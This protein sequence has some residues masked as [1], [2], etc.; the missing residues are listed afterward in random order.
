MPP[1]RA[2]AHAS[3][4]GASSS[5]T[6]G[7]RAL[8]T[9]Q[10]RE[11]ESQQRMIDE[12]WEQ[13]VHTFKIVQP[14]EWPR[15]QP[16]RL[17]ETPEQR[18]RRHENLQGEVPHASTSTSTSHKNGDST[19][20]Y[21][22]DTADDDI[23]VPPNGYPSIS[24]KHS[25]VSI[26]GG[27]DSGLS[28]DTYP[29]DEEELSAEAEKGLITETMEI[30]P[31]FRA[32]PKYSLCSST[33][34]DVEELVKSGRHLEA[35]K[36][37]LENAYHNTFATDPTPVFSAS[38]A[39]Y[40]L[41]RNEK[42]IPVIDMKFHRTLH[43]SFRKLLARRLLNGVLIRY[44]KGYFPRIFGVVEQVGRQRVVL[45]AY[46]AYGDFTEK[47]EKCSACR[48]S[49]IAEWKT[50]DKGKD[51]EKNGSGRNGDSRAH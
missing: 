46:T 43:F 48:H 13:R 15:D 41:G 10:E 25:Y 8:T 1:R 32:R 23:Y 33:V 17:D 30:M 27:S 7:N 12:Y 51:V 37:A 31:D 42:D 45:H 35:L 49:I 18:R 3:V 26:A 16:A 29:S 28:S 34:R 20:H 4:P 2:V 19:P 36:R 40:I 6:D 47:Y 21:S 22:G 9:G 24:M 50:G 39:V 11:D 44:P 14:D 38:I 5:N